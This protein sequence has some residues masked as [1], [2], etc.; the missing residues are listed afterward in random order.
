[1]SLLIY[2]GL[3]VRKLIKNGL[4]IKKPQ[5]MHSRARVRLVREARKKGRHS[6]V[7]KRFGSANARMPTK[8]LWMRRM[9]V[10]RRVLR[11]YREQAKID[12]HFYRELYV[13]VKG[14]KF[15]N[16]RV[17]IEHIHKELIDRAR[18]ATIAEQ[19]EALK[20][21]QKALREKKLAK[22]QLKKKELSQESTKPVAS[23]Q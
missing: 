8:L 21:K 16:K 1:M 13:K 3:L 22:Q 4:V 11:N 19:A 7:G 2:V 10:L 23:S 20:A 6:G 15:K 12:K 5:A 14:D 17:L 18:D 9:R